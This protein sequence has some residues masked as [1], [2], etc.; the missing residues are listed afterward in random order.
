MLVKMLSS[1]MSIIYGSTVLELV[2]L[3]LLV[4]NAS[5]LSDETCVAINSEKYMSIINHVNELRQCP[6]GKFFH[7]WRFSA[8]SVLRTRFPIDSIE[9]NYVRKVSNVIFSVVKPFMLSDIK[10][11][12][13]S[14]EALINIL[15]LDP[16]V[17]Y[18][19]VFLNF[20]AGNW[21][22]P[23]GVYLSHRYGGHQF[24]YW[25]GQLGDGRAILLGEYVN[26]KG[27]KWELQLKGSGRTPYS[28]VGDGRA[29]L[30]SSIREFLVSEAMYHLHIP[31]TR[32]ASLVMS[33]DTVW[34]DQFYDGHPKLEKTAVVLRLSKSWFRIGSL[35]IL[36]Y[37]REYMLLKELVDFIIEDRFP[38]IGK[39]DRFLKF[40]ATVVERTADL[41]AKW[42]AIGF[43]HGVCNTDNF[44]LLSVTIDYGPFGF[45]DNYNPGYV[46][47]TSDDEGRYS[48]QNQPS[49]GYFNLEKLM[50]AM[51][52]LL[53][54]ERAKIILYSYW[55]TFQEKYILYMRQKLGL[56]NKEIEDELLIQDLLKI[57]VRFKADYTMTFRE[58]SEISLEDLQLAKYPKAFWTLPNLSRKSH[59]S[60]TTW[61]K[62]YADRLQRNGPGVSDIVRMIKMQDVNPRYIL[63]NYMAE[64]AIHLATVGNFTEVEQ[65]LETLQ[66]PFKQNLMADAKG[67]ASSPPEWS[68]TIRVS[69]SS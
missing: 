28:R 48:F 11:V 8:N 50:I 65:L 45:M 20:V 37:S 2:L 59:D 4:T 23:S 61:V 32:A 26:Q 34:R 60:W 24:G 30:R 13:V 5:L 66:N 52:S 67:Y 58:L 6:K 15:D 56:L 27:E 41:I 43:T 35:E 9:Q 69:C 54:Q 25:A 53:F 29:V 21:I 18:D 14:S 51:G 10:L 22:H 46:P 63:R 17:K 55:E 38:W 39:Q 19:S 3:Q 68:K 42:Q 47:N 64:K 7:L 36:H 31:T 16:A 33:E 12:A 44:S 57:M 49:V 1:T 62:S 40:F